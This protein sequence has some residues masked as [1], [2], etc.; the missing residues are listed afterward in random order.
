MSALVLN[1]GN[2]LT[3]PSVLNS[4]N[5]NAAA[6]YTNYAAAVTGAGG[7]VYNSTNTQN[8]IADLVAA[9]VYGAA[10]IAWNGS[11]GAKGLGTAAPLLYGV[12]PGF[13][14][15]DTW[16]FSGGG[17]TRDTT[18]YSYPVIKMHDASG[19]M[20]WST[21][22]PRKANAMT[23]ILR[24]SYPTPQGPGVGVQVQLSP[25][26]AWSYTSGQLNFAAASTPAFPF[27]T[28]SG[29]TGSGI[30]G[31]QPAPPF[32]AVWNIDWS[33]GQQWMSP[34]AQDTPALARE[35]NNPPVIAVNAVVP[36]TITVSGASD[37]AIDEFIVL[38]GQHSRAQVIDL[39]T[40]RKARY[41]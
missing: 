10:G 7:T 18:T 14:A 40:R 3:V 19:A 5:Q 17:V 31:Y 8:L 34:N 39:V 27:F 23:I 1:S 15:N 37:V 12:G 35:H 4:R 38:N 22:V 28:G 20:E 16:P 29:K 32:F 24:S 36:I 33:A 25:G 6:I 26:Y 30:G 2:L 41:P 13:S 9:G 21:F 11:T